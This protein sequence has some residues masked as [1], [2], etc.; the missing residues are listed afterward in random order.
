MQQIEKLSIEVKKNKILD[1]I[2]DL[3]SSGIEF[4]NSEK[5]EDENASKYIFIW[6][7]LSNCFL[8]VNFG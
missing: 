4:L 3:H 7:F 6:K 1:K 2:K 5:K 8:P